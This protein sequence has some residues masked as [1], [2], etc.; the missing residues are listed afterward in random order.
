MSLLKSVTTQTSFVTMAQRQE[1]HWIAR[2]KQFESLGSFYKLVLARAR[3]RTRPKRKRLRMRRSK[4][5][6]REE[7]RE[8]EK[9]SRRLF[10][11]YRE[12]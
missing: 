1:G 8:E 6:S 9:E 5:R 3:E 10:S 4:G 11:T 7:R 12:R 2:R